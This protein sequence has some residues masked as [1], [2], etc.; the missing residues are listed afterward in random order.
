PQLVFERRKLLLGLTATLAFLNEALLK[1]EADGV[2]RGPVPGRS[3]LLP[4]RRHLLRRGLTVNG[5]ARRGRSALLLLVAVA[6]ERPP[7]LGDGRRRHERH[8][9][10]DNREPAGG[11][12]GFQAQGQGAT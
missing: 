8:G 6:A 4:R 11:A 7:A 2:F 3:G 10:A 9:N 5:F 1:L 12:G